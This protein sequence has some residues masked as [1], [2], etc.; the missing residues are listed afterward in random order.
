[1]LVIY[2]ISKKKQLRYDQID[3]NK[4][5]TVLIT[6]FKKKKQTNPS[7]LNLIK[8]MQP[9]RLCN[10]VS[11]DCWNK[12]LSVTMS[13]L[14]ILIEYAGVVTNTYNLNSWEAEKRGVVL[15]SRPAWAQF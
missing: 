14:E 8:K 12:L 7:S 9:G 3:Q 2:T 4:T 11:D 10:L 6:L 13:L 5:L 15:S 1:M